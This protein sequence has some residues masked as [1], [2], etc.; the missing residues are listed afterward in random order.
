MP[1]EPRAIHAFVEIDLLIVD[2]D[3]D[4]R[5]VL[6]D[7]A[8]ALGYRAEAVAS[9]SE[10]LKYAARAAVPVA[11]VDWSL[12]GM[13]GPDLA[14]ALEAAQPR[15]RVLLMTG[16]VHTPDTGHTVLRKPFSLQTLGEALRLAVHD[17]AR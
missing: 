17:R 3:E 15:M 6:T 10:A 13:A 12:A 5:E 11:L 9:A 1:H 14:R 16:H 4:L 7:A 2:D 8:S